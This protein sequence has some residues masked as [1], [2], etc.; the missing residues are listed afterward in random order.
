MLELNE[1]KTLKHPTSS[2]LLWKYWGK[3]LLG[4]C[5]ASRPSGHESLGSRPWLPRPR[6]WLPPSAFPLAGGEGPASCPWCCVLLV[7]QL[8][9]PPT[10]IPADC[11]L[12][13]LTR[14]GHIAHTRCPA[15]SEG[16]KPLP[17]S[18]LVPQ[19]N[20]AEIP[21]SLWEPWPGRSLSVCISSLGGQTGRHLCSPNLSFWPLIAFSLG[22]GKR[23]G[24]P[25]P[26]SLPLLKEWPGQ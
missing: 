13:P 15:R 8:C 4:L 14:A 3:I 26:A 18:F 6:A 20:L 19:T 12:V 25:G 21:A 5:Q 7:G 1:I 22:K 16:T 10:P 24:N 23:K 2:E 17:R 9:L 11:Q